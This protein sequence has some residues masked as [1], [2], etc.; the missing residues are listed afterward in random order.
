MIEAV[1]E[2]ELWPIGQQ[3]CKFSPFAYSGCEVFLLTLHVFSNNIFVGWFVELNALAK[4]V[5]R[6]PDAMSRD[7]ATNDQRGE[8]LSEALALGKINPRWQEPVFK[9]VAF[10]VGKRVETAKPFTECWELVVSLREIIFKTFIPKITFRKIYVMS[11]FD[12]SEI[13]GG[14]PNLASVA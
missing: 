5:D 4:M 2:Y 3:D 13:I 11:I 12:F 7:R 1:S 9:S 10:F 6:A 14:G 8:A